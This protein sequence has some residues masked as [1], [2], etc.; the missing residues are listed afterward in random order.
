ML[1]RPGK[2]LV[3]WMMNLVLTL[4]EL[5][6]PVLD[7]GADTLAP[8]KAALPLPEKRRFVGFGK[9]SACFQDALL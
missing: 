2:K 6:E 7:T 4:S 5:R 3:E 1:L 8:A 9:D